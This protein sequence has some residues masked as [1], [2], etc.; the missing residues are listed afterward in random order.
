[1]NQID[2][3]QIFRSF[4]TPLLFL[5]IT[6]LTILVVIYGYRFIMVLSDSASIQK[7]LENNE[8]CIFVYTDFD[9]TDLSCIDKKLDNGC[10]YTVSFSRRE[11][12]LPYKELTVSCNYK[13]N[14]NGNLE[15]YNCDTLRERFEKEYS[16]S[17][18][19]R[20]INILKDDFRISADRID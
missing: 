4:R 16:L 18:T 10:D 8:Y 14:L 20:G 12:V 11:I 17:T 15:I 7:D 2:Y 5:L 6:C 19:K 13:I 3:K 1:M 9:N